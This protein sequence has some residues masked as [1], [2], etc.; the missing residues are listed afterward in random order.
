MTAVE[1]QNYILSPAVIGES[2]NPSLIIRQPEV[3][4]L[5]P[6]L[7]PFNIGRRKLV[8]IDRT[9]VRRLKESREQKDAGRI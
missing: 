1:G 7:N 9:E 5:V 8:T 6:W 4:G 3:R 2:M